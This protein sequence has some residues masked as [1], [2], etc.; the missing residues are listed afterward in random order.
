MEILARHLNMAIPNY[1]PISPFKDADTSP[2]IYDSVQYVNKDHFVCEESKLVKNAIRDSGSVSNINSSNAQKLLR[3]QRQVSKR[4]VEGYRTDSKTAEDELNSE[5]STQTDFN[6]ST[7]LN[8]HD[9]TNAYNR[10]GDSNIVQLKDCSTDR[11]D[12]H[13]NAREITISVK[14]EHL[15]ST[16]RELQCPA[17]PLKKTKLDDNA[18]F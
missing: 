7:I 5:G 10:F 4:N 16:V 14:S 11:Q 17:V 3:P 12:E 15:G 2:L 8:Q 18:A 6:D 13:C 9:V 1:V